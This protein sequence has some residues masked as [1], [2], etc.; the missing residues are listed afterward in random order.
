MEPGRPIA[1]QKAVSEITLLFTDIEGSTKIV[2]S[3][4]EAYQ[5]ILIQHFS[6]L[7]DAVSE[8]RGREASSHSDAFFA[9]FDRSE[10]AVGAAI[11]IQRQMS[12]AT[13]PMPVPLKVRVGLHTGR[14]VEAVERNVG[15][16]GVDVHR[17]ARIADAANGGQILMSAATYSRLG[18]QFLPV[19]TSIRYAGLH[20]LK[21]LR[22]PENIYEVSLE[23]N[24]SSPPIRSL[25]TRRTNLPHISSAFFGREQE[26]AD[27]RALLRHGTVQIVTLTGPGGSGKTRLSVEASQALT[28]VFPGGVF[29]VALGGVKEPALVAASIAETLGVPEFP[30]YPIV[31]GLKHAIGN[32]SMLLVVDNFEQVIEAGPLLSDMAGSC[33]NLKF[34]VTSREALRVTRE[35]EVK[36]APLLLPAS[37]GA[38]PEDLLQNAAIRLF[39]DRARR[40]DPEFVMTTEAAPLAAEICRRLDGLPLAIEL[41]ASR[42]KLLNL[43]GLLN[44]LPG[45]LSAVRLA[46][47]DVE[48]RHSSLRNAIAWSYEL[49]SR[50]EQCVFS[51][52]SV[53]IGGFDLASAEAVTGRSDV[54][55]TIGSLIDKSLL[56]TETQEG[57]RRFRMLETIREFG[58]G[59]LAAKQAA[60]DTGAKHAACFL[61][62]AEKLAPS[63]ITSDQRRAVSRLLADADNIRAALRW[64]MDRKKTDILSR[65]LRAMLWFWIPQSRFTEGNAWIEE[66]FQTVRTSGS[67]LGRAVI[68]DVG[69]WLRMISGDYSGALPLFVEASALYEATGSD[70]DRTRTLMALGIT[71]AVAKGDMDGVR[72]ITDALAQYRA[73]GNVHG[74]GLALIALGEGARAQGDAGTAYS[75]YGQALDA[76]RT[77]S[78]MYWIAALLLNMAQLR[79]HEGD[80]QT[81]RQLLN[82]A[83]AIGQEYNYPMVINLYLAATGRLALCRG[84]HA[85]AA[86]LIGATESLLAALGVTFEPADQAML[87]ESAAAAR[88]AL[89]EASYR[90]AYVV[91]RGWSQQEAITATLDLA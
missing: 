75:C 49:L 15:Y 45:S 61:D 19:G 24:A 85:E 39:A 66:A 40:T 80:W 57:E 21:D 87:D 91:G 48:E 51:R 31:D 38:V 82:E 2:Q 12:A 6:I 65:M 43:R 81:A 78:D 56:S 9:V 16:V 73:A 54:L 64:A 1:F 58:L 53:F 52:L 86:R 83:L 74:A 36:L 4:G 14:P 67:D 88:A 10:D 79:L 22:Y 11:A 5:Q 17:A 32:K 28:E 69:G 63:L 77:S 44:H 27:L 76:M 72:M 68:L 29:Q 18:E 46:S 47:R 37:A 33:A 50:E 26:L 8:H 71:T 55:E 34:L 35:V 42:M 89:G 59:C 60:D 13:W 25:S 20:R 84:C 41:A 7:R 70:E 90:S 30:G 23:P 3:V 62:L